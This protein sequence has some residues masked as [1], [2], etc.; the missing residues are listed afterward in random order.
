MI[1]LEVRVN[2]MLIAAASLVNRGVL[3]GGMHDYEAQYTMFTVD[4]DG[5]P[6]I[7]HFRVEHARRDGAMKLIKAVVERML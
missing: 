2:G 5:P 4:N 3:E 1:S 6:A 7:G